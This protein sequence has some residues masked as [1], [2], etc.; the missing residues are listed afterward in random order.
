MK[1]STPKKVPKAQENTGNS[2]KFEVAGLWKHQKLV[3][4]TP[5]TEKYWELL[6]EVQLFN[7]KPKRLV[8]P[9]LLDS[10][11]YDEQKSFKNVR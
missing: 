8:L 5:H 3:S 4:G 2:K 7:E 1:S 11:E 10:P 6:D 9:N